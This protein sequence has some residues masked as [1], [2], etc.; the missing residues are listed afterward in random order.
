MRFDYDLGTDLSLGTLAAAVDLSPDGTRVVFA[1]RGKDGKTRLFLHPLDREGVS[2][3]SG[4]EGAIHPFF[5]PDGQWIG[6]FADRKLKKVSAQGGAAVTLCDA[7][8]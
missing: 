2:P 7:S 8:G 3:L 6:F 1:G 4:T 5:S